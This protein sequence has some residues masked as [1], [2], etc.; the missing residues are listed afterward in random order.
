VR[1]YELGETDAAG[2]SGSAVQARSWPRTQRDH[3]ELNQE[4]ANNTLTFAALLDMRSE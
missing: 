2:K 4:M 3:E 1:L